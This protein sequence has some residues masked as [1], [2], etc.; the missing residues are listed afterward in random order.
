MCGCSSSDSTRG[1]FA[2][3]YNPSN[4]NIDYITMASTGNA[5]DFGDLTVARRSGMVTG[6]S[7]NAIFVGGYIPGVNN[8]IDKVTIQTTGNA[9][10]WGDQ[11]GT[12][13]HEGA[14]S[15]DSHGGIS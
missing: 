3:G 2:G 10:D 15:S 12:A 4:N 14:C 8:T 1:L 7:I 5:T 11:T 9:V 13:Y 6:N